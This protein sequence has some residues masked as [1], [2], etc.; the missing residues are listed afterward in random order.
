V[1]AYASSATSRGQNITIE[2]RHHEGKVERLA[3]LAT[4][5]VRLNCDVIV[6]NGTE[7][8][9]AAKNVIKT[10]PVVMGFAADAV[11]RGIVRDLARPGGNITGLT[12]IR[13]DINGKRLELLKEVVPK[14]SRV[15]FLWNPTYVG[16]GYE[17]KEI[18]TVP[19]LYA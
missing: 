17:L 11:S 9:E 14:L 10:I 4:E 1:N 15:G 7:A 12:D 5:L 8:A 6:T 13:A 3:D 18:E 16:A 19:G 2:I